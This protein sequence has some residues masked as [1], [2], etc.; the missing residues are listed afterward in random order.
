MADQPQQPPYPTPPPDSVVLNAFEGLKN[1]V[2]RERLK[3]TELE[4][5]K[6]IDLDD[7]GQPR[8]RRGHRKVAN[9]SWHSLYSDPS[10]LVL[11]VK[12]NV[13]GIIYPDYSF[14]PLLPNIGPEY[15]DYVRVGDVIYFSSY[16]TSGKFNLA[17]G[18][19]YPWGQIGGD[20][21]WISPV[22]HPDTTLGPV[23]GRLLGKVPM[24]NCLDYWNGR[25]YM[26]CGR[27]VWATE[28]WLYDLVD[29][30][31]TFLPFENDV[32]MVAAVTDGLYVGTDSNCYFLS[33]ER[34]TGGSIKDLKRTTLMNYGVLPRSAVQVPAEL[35]KP[36]ISQD[37][38]SPIKNAVM[39]M[40]HTGVIAGFD[41]GVIYNLTQADY[42]FP[43]ADRAATMFR[44]QDGINQFVA[45]LNSDGD[46]S[47]SARIG[48]YVDVEIRRFRGA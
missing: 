46:P 22:V 18:Q 38:Q 35:I 40:T 12:D 8:R 23:W 21:Q 9:G 6:N 3:P 15:L 25:I 7:A 39:F 44:R 32:T 43:V 4:I 36:Q 42:L 33:Y 26:G 34:Q 24:A 27:V 16:A 2:T 14:D 31:R 11:G 47:E 13:L 10:G 41:G 17:S 37:P 5:A 1:T 30:T 29:A 48:D 20:K 28:L 45:V 19:V